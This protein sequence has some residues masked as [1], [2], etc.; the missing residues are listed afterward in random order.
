MK[1]SPR[2]KPLQKKPSRRAPATAPKLPLDPARI[3]AGLPDGVLVT[4]SDWQIRY[5][6]RALLQAMESSEKDLLGTPLRLLPDTSGL[7]D[8]S[9]ELLHY[10]AHL[11]SS[12]PEQTEVKTVSVHTPERKFIRITTQPYRPTPSQADGYILTFAIYAL[13]EVGFAGLW[14]YRWREAGTD[15]GCPFGLFYPSADR[16]NFCGTPTSRMVG[17]P[18]ASVHPAQMPPSSDAE[19]DTAN[20]RTQLLKGTARQTFDLYVNNA[21]W[22]AG[23]AYV[24]QIDAAEVTLLT[25]EQLDQLDSYFSRKHLGEQTR[26]RVS[27][28]AMRVSIATVK[29]QIPGKCLKSGEFLYCEPSIVP[30]KRTD[31]GAWLRLYAPRWLVFR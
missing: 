2:K 11:T 16:H 14:G 21:A 23:L 27:N 5:V 1:Q 31:S 6:N 9:S 28:E 10:L 25:S 3:L 26:Y 7:G 13:S 29:L 15:D 18:D 4:D 17:I 20:L 19:M 8:S 30:V 22:N 24:Q 12:P